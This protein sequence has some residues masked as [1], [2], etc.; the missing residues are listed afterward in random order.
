MQEVVGTSSDN[1][2]FPT[3]LD[4]LQDSQPPDLFDQE[5]DALTDTLDKQTDKIQ[6]MRKSNFL[7]KSKIDIL[8]DILQ[9]QKE[10]HQDLK[11]ELNRMLV[12][13]Q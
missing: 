10:K 13:I 5:R 4:T 6:L 8:S 9:V 7:L 3:T 1:Y 12:D 11:Q 2:I